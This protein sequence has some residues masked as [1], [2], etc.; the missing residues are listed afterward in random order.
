M[1]R[2][3]FA[4]LIIPFIMNTSS[5]SHDQPVDWSHQ[6]QSQY[7]E[8]LEYQKQGKFKSAFDLS[9]ILIDRSLDSLNVPGLVLGL[10]SM[11]ENT[12]EVDED[13][14]S[15][16]IASLA[17]SQP[18]NEVIAAFF[19]SYMGELTGIY[20]ERNQ[21]R[22]TEGHPD[23]PPLSWS[24]MHRW[25][26]MDYENI[27]DSFYRESV[28]QPEKL[29]IPVKKAKHILTDDS[30]EIH[31]ELRPFIY[32][33]LQDRYLYYLRNTRLHR[34]TVDYVTDQETTG[35]LLS[36]D[37]GKFL[38]RENLKED[39]FY[40]IINAWHEWE[41]SLKSA[42]HTEAWLDVV[43]QRLNFVFPAIPQEWNNQFEEALKRL[44]DDYS[45]LK[46]SSAISVRRAEYLMSHQDYKKALAV[47]EAAVQKESKESLPF[48]T[49]KIRSLIRQIQNVSLTVQSEEVYPLNQYP[50]IYLRHK[51]L[52]RAIVELYSIS[53][54]T[55]IEKQFS[56]NRTSD[57]IP[58]FSDHIWQDTVHF[59][60]S[61]DFQEH[62]SEIMIEENLPYGT[63]AL[64]YFA[65][66]D[67][68][69]IEGYVFFQVS[70]IGLMMTA[71]QQDAEIRVVNRTD[72]EILENA[73][74]E[75]KTYHRGTDQN[76]TGKNLIN[77][78]GRFL[79][80]PS[81]TSNIYFIAEHGED[82]YISP[83]AYL[84]GNYSND[85]EPY[86][87]TILFTDRA[88]YQ[89]GD[90]I[91]F[92]ALTTLSK[93]LTTDLLKNQKITVSLRDG[94]GQEV[95]SQDYQTDEWGSVT[96]TAPVPSTGLKGRWSLHASPSGN[97]PVQVEEYVRPNFEITIDDENIKRADHQ[98]KFKGTASTYN[99][100][101]IQSAEGEI[102]VTLEK[103][104]WFYGNQSNPIPLV[105]KNFRTDQEGV[106]ELSFDEA[107]LRDLPSK[108]YGIYVYHIK[109]S[110]RAESGE[111]RETEKRIPLDPDQMIL[112][113]DSRAFYAFNDFSP[114]K[115]SVKNALNI[116]G[117]TEVRWT[118]EE[119]E[120]PE[121][122]KVDRYW[123]LPDQKIISREKMQEQQPQLFYDHGTSLEEWP[124]QKVVEHGERWINDGDSLAVN[125]WI[126]K[127]GY[128][129][130]TLRSE[131][132]DTLTSA[133]FGVAGSNQDFKLHHSPVEFISNPE[134]TQPGD[135]LH[136]KVLTAPELK[137]G[138]LRIAHP[139]GRIREINIIEENE[140]QFM[141][142]ESDRGG[143]YIQTSGFLQ[144]RYF[145]KT[146]QIDVPWN[147][148]ELKVEITPFQE[149][150]EVN[151]DHQLKIKIQDYQNQGVSSEV[152]V[153]IYDA[154][155]DAYIPHSWKNGHTFYRM[156]ANPLSSRNL[157]GNLGVIRDHVRKDHRADIEPIP[158]RIPQLIGFM[159][160]YTW[161]YTGALQRN[162]KSA[163]P[164]PGA[165]ME[166]SSAIMSDQAMAGQDGSQESEEIRFRENFD[167]MMLFR[168]KS[169][170]DADGN[171]TIPFET[172]DKAGRWK[173]LVFAHTPSLQYGEEEM[174]FETSK[175]IYLEDFFPSR[176]RQGDQIR[177]RSTLFNTVDQQ[178]SGTI[179]WKVFPFFD[180][181]PI[182][183][184][185]V[186]FEADG[187]SSQVHHMDFMVPGDQNSPVII[188][189]VAKDAT[190]KTLDAIEK[191]IPV[192]S[193]SQVIHEG[194]IFVLKEGEELTEEDWK[195]LR[196]KGSNEI[197]FR[198]VQNMYSELMKSIP[199]L[200]Y[201]NPVTTD[202]YFSNAL[203]ALMGQYI[204]GQIP[205]FENIY[206]EWKRKGELTS[207][208]AQ[209]EGKKY[210]D[211]INTPWVKQSN[212]GREQMI[213]LASYF[214]KN[215]MDELIDGHLEKWKNSQNPDGGFP[216]IEGGSSSFYITN[217]FLHKQ[218]KMTWA[219]IDDINNQENVQLR[220]LDYLDA[221]FLRRYREREKKGLGLD[222]RSYLNYFNTRSYFPIKEKSDT[223]MDAW[224]TLLD[225]V[226]A[227]WT[228]MP[229][230][231]RAAIGIA[232]FY[233][234]D[235]E[236]SKKVV[237]S[238]LDNAIRDSEL[239]TYWKN[240]SVGN[241]T[242]YLKTLADII[243]LLLIND[244]SELNEEITQWILIHKMTNDWHS[245]PN[246]FSLILSLLK[247]QK[248]FSHPSAIEMKVNGIVDTLHG[249]GDMDPV[250]WKKGDETMVLKNVK[251]HPVWIGMMTSRTVKPEQIT[252]PAGDIL[253]IHKRMIQSDDSALSLGDKV[254]IRL[255]ITADRDM[256]YVYIEDPLV[257]GFDAGINL[258][259]WNWN[260]GLS[261]YRSFGHESV[262]L[263]IRHLPR[264]HYTIE[265]ELGV[266]REG[267][268]VFPATVIQSYFV[269]EINGYDPWKT[270]L[271]VK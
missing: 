23:E 159:P 34:S 37:L 44:T 134:T 230:A 232:A 130:L 250:V 124:V 4:L 219:G 38:S 17:S 33:L 133:S 245:N 91:H 105:R 77:K 265:Y 266:V 86:R 270:H 30:A 228:E 170:T 166:E 46:N 142:N 48:Y 226:R 141:V 49:S 162:M 85:T 97:V 200:H 25:T 206:D 71:D 121:H 81:R 229:M 61:G 12:Y 201:S 164:V 101:P 96:G 125:Q 93:K 55:F 202:Q 221:E 68:T 137:G 98:I 78:N 239:G 191:V 128:Y 182:M 235:Q 210:T 153:A 157:S 188:Q 11:I 212:S 218:A 95:W 28:R 136:I 51:N 193:A 174:T 195:D 146:K 82:R 112:S 150:L 73:I 47:L 59:S 70:D 145:S 175:S 264:G 203:N 131:N 27:I 67:S 148:K 110:I 127:D 15:E 107:K 14:V 18:E 123:D 22:I 248:D 13:L 216:W 242:D 260:Q 156:M 100:F 267:D 173:V 211:L 113:L 247:I 237:E 271:Q 243:E 225:S 36:N 180:E 43:L 2:Y 198:I 246:V 254:R 102:E 42:G 224:T 79:L 88:I 220:A 126:S 56:P 258:S 207:R 259:G 163:A 183:I 240:N 41:I 241:Q 75:M 214:D 147:Q 35:E 50:L 186:S 197:E 84:Y 165:V 20:Y 64:K 1:I 8:I 21:H 154:S 255:E 103:V 135:T 209:N 169:K 143:I 52:N 109:I 194:K 115:L 208:L 236:W 181:D 171:L 144:G 262:Q 60:N 185:S 268:F 205:D 261:F 118:L 39:P 223:W 24:E 83:L 94:N 90:L 89:P 62:G 231:D 190:G 199:Y 54:N 57:S 155:L 106:F 213:R 10:K 120:S 263:F 58:L 257:A 31:Y 160:A 92:K 76:E 87:R 5:R 168:G 66:E 215:Q 151:S 217:S 40:R 158:F 72:G 99:G 149:A 177:L 65:N 187:K 139:D 7:D 238:F 132:G 45:H 16:T 251:G 104:P 80:P 269:P 152:A 244:T 140:F 117:S 63:Y 129:R 256:D 161:R 179:E 249:I 29:Q 3:I 167:E 9:T 119:L 114:L 252:E 176:L 227:H 178:E 189:I 196:D 138:I 253:K 69:N 172:N 111:I 192:L 32:D 233:I 222:Y 74:L 204:V 19:N 53:E 116:P 6:F 108:R 184:H 26:G 122:F 234:G